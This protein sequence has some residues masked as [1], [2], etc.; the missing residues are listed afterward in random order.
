MVSRFCQG[1]LLR[2]VDL[3]P[4]GVVFTLHLRR[5]RG[6]CRGAD[7]FPFASRQS[8][9]GET[10]EEHRNG[11]LESR[12]WKMEDGKWNASRKDIPSPLTWLKISVDL[13]RRGS[14]RSTHGS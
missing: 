10:D 8:T 6:L 9:T 14:T 1:K 11:E 12:N 4:A 2:V 5:R 13:E 7:L 3:E